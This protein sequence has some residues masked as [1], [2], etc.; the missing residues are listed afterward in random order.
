VEVRRIEVDV[1]EVGMVKRPAQ[2]G[3]Y[4]L[5]KALADAAHL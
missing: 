3:L 1:G 4:L 2:K 5:I